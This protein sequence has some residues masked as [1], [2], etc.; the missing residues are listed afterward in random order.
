MHETVIAHNIIQE[1]SKYGNVKELYI[2]AGELAHVPPEELLDCLKSL[3]DWKIHFT[4]VPAKVKCGCGFEGKPKIL[5]RSHDSFLIECPKCGN[6]PNLTEG[7]DIKI[8]K[9]VVE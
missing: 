1:A 5:E 8:T 3:V 2:E 6:V 4:I 9:V 7:K